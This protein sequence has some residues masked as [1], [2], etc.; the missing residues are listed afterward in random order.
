MEENEL[1]AASAS[2]EMDAREKDD[3]GPT[4]V[5]QRT[6]SMKFYY[7]FG[8]AVIIAALMSFGA[9]V[10]CIRLALQQVIWEYS[11]QRRRG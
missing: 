11:M 9:Y 10:I 5:K 1:E 2:P 4:P 7:K 8:P 3:H 6:N